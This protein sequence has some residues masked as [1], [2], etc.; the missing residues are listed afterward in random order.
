MVGTMATQ[1]ACHSVVQMVEM[2]VDWMV[3]LTVERTATQMACHW[4]VQMATQMVEQMAYT[5][6]MVEMRVG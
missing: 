1:M 5:T 3:S 6:R 4:V 2:R